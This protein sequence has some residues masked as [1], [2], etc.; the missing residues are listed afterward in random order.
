MNLVSIA[1]AKSIGM[2]PVDAMLTETHSFSNE[3]TSIPIE[4]GAEVTDHVISNPDQIT[5]EGFIGCTPFD[6]GG[7]VTGGVA[8]VL[9]SLGGGGN[10]VQQ[11]HNMLLQ[12]KTMRAP[13][14]VV[15]GLNVYDNMIIESYEVPR[16]VDTG[17]DLHF[18]MTLKKVRIVSS[19]N[20]M[21]EVATL[22]DSS[23]G[24]GSQ[25]AGAASAGMAPSVDAADSD[26]MR[27]LA[28]QQA[29]G[30]I[31]DQSEMNENLKLWGIKDS[32]YEIFKS[33]NG[34]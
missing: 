7:G 24:V 20:I 11:Y 9:S 21:A 5:I 26:V 32:D 30:T 15:T 31:A 12:L 18:T 6:T 2:V 3:I 16:D 1:N 8:S 4:M 23:G 33:Q 29:N 13:I 27:R 19:T 25:I 14:S 34:Y 28:E 22:A 10:R 17:A